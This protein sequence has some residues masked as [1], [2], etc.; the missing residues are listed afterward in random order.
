MRLCEW[1]CASPRGEK[2]HRQHRAREFRIANIIRTRRT[3]LR[4][5]AR[6]GGESAFSGRADRKRK[7]GALKSILDSSFRYTPSSA[8]DLRKTFARVRLE[9]QAE[10][11][12]GEQE[13]IA[14]DQQTSGDLSAGA[15]YAA[16]VS[17][18][19]D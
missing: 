2:N 1:H 14:Q 18:G 10:L 15:R 16:L 13:R 11:R 3:P 17:A 9:Q 6:E 4:S 7:D 19:E 8:T 12:P 5:E